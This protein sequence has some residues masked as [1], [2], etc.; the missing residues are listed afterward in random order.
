MQKFA[1]FSP[2]RMKLLFNVEIQNLNPGYLG[3]GSPFNRLLLLHIS[4][5]IE[6]GLT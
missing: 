6:R 5:E 2:N 3:M 4:S 1:M